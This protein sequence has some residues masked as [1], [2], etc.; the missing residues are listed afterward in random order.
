MS[1]AF[2][3]KSLPEGLRSST[4]LALLASLGIHGLLWVVLPNIPF[5]SKPVE[6][7]LQ[8][9]IGVVQ[10]TPEELSR[11][12]QTATP[13]V[14]LPAFATQPSALPPLPPPPN[15]GLFSQIPSGVP[16]SSN[17]KD[18]LKVPFQ[19]QF[20]DLAQLPVPNQNRPAPAQPDIQNVPIPFQ[21]EQRLPPPPPA[22]AL[23]QPAN[24]QLP[25][26]QKLPPPPAAWRQP[27]NSQLPT[28]A[29]KPAPMPDF[30]TRLPALPAPTPGS[31]SA[32]TP[33]PSAS[34]PQVL[35][36][37]QPK[38]SQE[39][40]A[41]LL[42]RREQLR[43][44]SQASSSGSTL[45]AATEDLSNWVAEVNPT[46]W[47]KLTISPDYP[48]QA[49][50]RQLAGTA[51]VLVLVNPQGNITN[52]PRLN[53]TTGS[54]ILD[55]AALAAVKAYEF[56]SISDA[57]QAYLFG[58]EYKYDSANCTA[59][60]SA[61]PNNHNSVTPATPQNRSRLRSILERNSAAPPTTPPATSEN[62]TAAPPAT[63]EQRSPLR[64]L[65]E[66]RS[67][68]P[69]ATPENETAQPNS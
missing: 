58:V 18:L 12:P 48:K 34:Q 22:L 44:S 10:L 36:S 66:E 63:S 55:G 29:V 25:A 57:R 47:H 38:V 67:V 46:S 45:V 17:Y 28:V 21:F 20:Q 13:P 9:S 19:P 15:L 27:T 5:H 7:D 37:T 68:T 50:P 32:A 23:R 3:T 42:A 30:L 35:S 52:G 41:A 49:C 31:N 69:E 24:S 64:S 53:K 26:Q 2:P 61:A 43:Q 8:Q 56:K 16:N 62:S 60:P 39:L 40:I 33:T 51:S 14:E 65:L 11:L 59:T 4:N 1:Y 6:A 54:S